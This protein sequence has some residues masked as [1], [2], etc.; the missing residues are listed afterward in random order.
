MNFAMHP[1][2]TRLARFVLLSSVPL[3]AIALLWP[4]EHDRSSFFHSLWKPELNSYTGPPDYVVSQD[5]RYK[6]SPPRDFN[7]LNAAREELGSILLSRSSYRLVVGTDISDHG[8]LFK[9]YVRGIDE[10]KFVSLEGG[11]NSN[12]LHLRSRYPRGR[13]I[14]FHNGHGQSY[15]SSVFAVLFFLQN[16]YDVLLFDMPGCGVNRAREHFHDS[17]TAYHDTLP[18]FDGSDKSFLRFFVTPVVLSLDYLLRS[19]RFASIAMT[20]LSGGGWTTVLAAAVDLR[21]QFSFPVAGSLPLELRVYSFERGDS[22]QHSPSFYSRFSYLDLYL[23][24]SASELIGPRSQL[25]IFFRFD[26]CC[27]A[28]DRATLYGSIVRQHSRRLNGDFDVRILDFAAHEFSYD[29]A[30]IVHSE[31]SRLSR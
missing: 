25:Q 15:Y 27:F 2:L 22:E 20:G 18:V 10:L 11:P 23:L 29:S 13:L 16:G 7:G 30:L 17:C 3:L 5:V 4:R 6:F 19:S 26:P 21:I 24:G 31:I 8:Y 12:V 14:L 28:G 1:V 9:D